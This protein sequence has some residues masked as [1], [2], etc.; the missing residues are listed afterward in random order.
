MNDSV[1]LQVCVSVYRGMKGYNGGVVC[2]CVLWPNQSKNNLEI[3]LDLG[4]GNDPEYT[5]TWQ[6]IY[7]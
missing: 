6:I 2:V 5:Q 1:Q 4:F 7:I 3:N